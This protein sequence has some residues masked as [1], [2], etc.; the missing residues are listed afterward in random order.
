[1]KEYIQ[2]I[3]KRR[4]SD[5]VTD[6]LKPLIV[7]RSLKPGDRLPSERELSLS[8][9]VSRPSIRE[10][11]RTLNILGLVD[12]KPG[13]GIFVKGPDPDF[14]RKSLQETLLI[15]MEMEKKTF[16]EILEVRIILEGR[17]AAIAARNAD[18][19]EL[20]SLKNTFEAYENLV[21]EN[22]AQNLVLTDFDFHLAIAKC[23]HNSVLY[24]M[25]NIIEDVVSRAT[26]KLI[27][28][29]DPVDFH[30][31]ICRE[32]KKILEPILKRSEEEASRAMVK[33]LQRAQRAM[34]R[35]INQDQSGG[36]NKAKEGETKNG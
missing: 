8:F 33:H 13:H 4:F 5:E 36:Q 18:E 29:V 11:I 20:A 27:S 7:E 6:Q 22:G 26:Q 24:V 14:Y 28:S 30:R 15:H 10:A 1:M 32:H 23:S 19:N 3:T 16:F 9:Q 35:I 25:I 17:T 21:I 31:Q 34:D 12:I 2:P